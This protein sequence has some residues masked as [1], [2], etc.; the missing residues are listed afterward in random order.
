MI[1]DSRS[2]GLD[3]TY[4]N[5]V[6]QSVGIV[7]LTGALTHSKLDWI[8]FGTIKI[9]YMILEHSCRKPEV[10]VKC[11]VRNFNNLVYIYIFIRHK[12]QHQ[13]STQNKTEEKNINTQV[14]TV[15]NIKVLRVRSDLVET[16]SNC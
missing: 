2:Y 5:L 6:Y 12:S 4:A 7:Y 1:S 10:V 16:D 14:K 11:C 9:L 15:I 8:N 3:M 13:H